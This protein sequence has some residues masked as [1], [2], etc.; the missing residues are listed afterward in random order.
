MTHGRQGL[1]GSTGRGILSTAGTG[2]GEAGAR[3]PHID[4]F[5]WETGRFVA[6]GPAEGFRGLNP[7]P[8]TALD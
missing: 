4:P 6:I 1:L 7:L 5:A 2:R 8:S 3:M